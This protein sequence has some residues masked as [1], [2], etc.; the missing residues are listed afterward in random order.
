MRIRSFDPELC[1][2]VAGWVSTHQE[3]LHLAPATGYPLTAAKVAAW[4]KP[5]GHVFQLTTVD[6]PG[7]LGYAEL[8][9]L[10]NDP[11]QYWLGHVIV[12]PDQRGRGLGERF[13]RGLVKIGFELLGAHRISL[14]VFCDNPTAARCYERVG[15]SAVRNEQHSFGGKGPKHKVLRMEIERPAG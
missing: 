2:V 15:F 4:K 10:Q 9:P 12:K 5:D 3:M 14:I 13:V 1:S 11:T 8:N 7:L 6:D